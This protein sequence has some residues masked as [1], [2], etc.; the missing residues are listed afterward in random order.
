L[1]KIKEIEAGQ[2]KLT[3]GILID[4]SKALEVT[5]NKFSPR[6]YEDIR[7]ELS[8]V[9][10]KNEVFGEILK[11]AF[12]YGALQEKAK[13]DEN[14]KSALEDVESKWGSET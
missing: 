1:K 2:C 8:S 14:L 11:F 12:S 9:F 10:N 4:L 3:I 13:S 7:G 6:Q 5:W